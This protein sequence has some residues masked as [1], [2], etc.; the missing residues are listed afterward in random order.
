MRTRTVW[1]P[2]VGVAMVWAVW[3]GGNVCSAREWEHEAVVE[4]VEAY[5]DALLAGDG[6]GLAD[7]LGEPMRSE[8]Q[9]RFSNPAY[10]RFL[11]RI[12]AGV[13]YEVGEIR[14]IGE[15]EASMAYVLLSTPGN[16][17]ARFGFEVK[18][19]DGDRLRVVRELGTSAA[20]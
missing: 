16:G 6:A 19:D 10:G 18:P 14:A 13:R 11:R 20:K 2:V 7:A 8:L 3:G 15:G 17:V 4:A 5:L 9:S 12:Y 1:G